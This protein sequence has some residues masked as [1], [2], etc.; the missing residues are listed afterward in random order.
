[1]GSELNVISLRKE[2]TCDIWGCISILCHPPSVLELCLRAH[3]RAG[4]G[5]DTEKSVTWSLPSKSSWPMRDACHSDV[6]TLF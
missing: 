2:N 6:H 3:L 1:M 5:G 4:F